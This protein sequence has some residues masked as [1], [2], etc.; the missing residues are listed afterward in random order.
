M[1]YLFFQIIFFMKIGMKIN[2]NELIEF[3]LPIEN[4]EIIQ[5]IN[6]S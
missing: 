5:K 4:I 6:Q 2:K 3:I 1:K